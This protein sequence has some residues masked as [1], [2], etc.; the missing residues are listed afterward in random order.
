A[1]TWYT[2]IVGQHGGALM[3]GKHIGARGLLGA[4]ALT[5][6]GLLG[7]DVGASSQGGHGGAGGQATGSPSASSGSATTASG[8]S[9]TATTTGASTTSGGTTTGSS[10]TSG[11]TTT[12]SSASSASSTSGGAPS[13]MDAIKNGNETGVDCGGSC[14]A[15]VSYQTGS[16][17]TNTNVNNACT[18]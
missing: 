6:L 10:T 7:C 11:G 2:K 5:G 4:A 1:G 12:S 15:C 16:P 18:A 9:G 13:C 8:T 17:D 3:I 14:P